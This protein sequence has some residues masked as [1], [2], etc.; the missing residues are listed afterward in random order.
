[1]EEKETG[2]E[3]ERN[4]KTCRSNIVYSINAFDLPSLASYHTRTQFFGV[5]ITREKDR[6]IV[7]IARQQ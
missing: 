3:K 6:E 2:R 5:F 4:E 7:E 1:M